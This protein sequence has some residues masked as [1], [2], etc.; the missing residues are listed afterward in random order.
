MPRQRLRSGPRLLQSLISIPPWTVPGA[1]VNPLNTTGNYDYTRANADHLNDYGCSTNATYCNAGSGLVFADPYYGGRRSQYISFSFGLQKQINKKAVF[2]AD[3]S[4]S[5]TYFLPGGS[6]RGF[7]INTFSPDYLVGFGDSSATAG[8]YTGTT[9][10][11]GI[12]TGSSLPTLRRP[13]RNPAA[14]PEALP[15]IQRIYRRLGKHRKRKL[16]LLAVADHPAPVA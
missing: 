2:S 4:G 8:Y 14:V 9:P 11:G 15:A 3:Y 12:I 10:T 5:D 1:S 16:Q 7:A 6:G 13:R